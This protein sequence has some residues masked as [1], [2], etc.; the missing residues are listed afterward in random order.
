MEVTACFFNYIFNVLASKMVRFWD[1]VQELKTLPAKDVADRCQQIWNEYLTE[2][3][4]STINID[5]R[6]LKATKEK[7]LNPDRWT[8]DDAAVSAGK[9]DQPRPRFA[10]HRFFLTF[11]FLLSNQGHVFHLMR[12]DTYSRY[13]RSDMYK[14][15]LAGCKKKVS[16]RYPSFYLYFIL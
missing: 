14:E 6:S 15:Y 8:F 13:L 16:T 2:D 12:S 3:A 4:T 5:A 10:L 11:I 7:M 1:D 9:S